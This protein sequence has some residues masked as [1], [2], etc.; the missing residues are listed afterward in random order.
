MSII[1]TNSNGIITILG[2]LQALPFT[3]H[4]LALQTFAI[5]SVHARYCVLYVGKR[6]PQSLQTLCAGTRSPLQYKRKRYLL[7]CPAVMSW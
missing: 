1:E 4:V 3:A 6:W 7:L 5:S 2:G